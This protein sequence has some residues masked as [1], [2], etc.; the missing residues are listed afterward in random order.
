VQTLALSLPQSDTRA[1]DCEGLGRACTAAARELK[2]AR[3]LIAGYEA[4]ITASDERIELARREIRTLQ[5]VGQLQTARAKQLEAVI[6]AEREAKAVLVTLKDE[7]SR[8]I[9]I[10]EKQLGRS[11]DSDRDSQVKN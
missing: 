2:A 4:H 3:E 7:Q 8:R 6:A 10:L 1:S 9:V 5:D 11:R